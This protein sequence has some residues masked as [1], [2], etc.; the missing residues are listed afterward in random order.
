MIL[1]YNEARMIESLAAL[2][3]AAK[4]GPWYPQGQRSKDKAVYRIGPAE[5][6][7]IIAMR[8]ALPD[9]LNIIERLARVGV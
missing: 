9:L 2:D 5:E 6:A 1:S 7:L 4:K 3:K 8:N